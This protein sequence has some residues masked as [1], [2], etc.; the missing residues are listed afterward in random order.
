MSHYIYMRA[1][2]QFILSFII[3]IYIAQYFFPGI[4]VLGTIVNEINVWS[5]ILIYVSG[6]YA[7]LMIFLASLRSFIEKRTKSLRTED[8]VITMVTFI[9]AAFIYLYFGAVS[10]QQTLINNLQSYVWNA[11]WGVSCFFMLLYAYRRFRFM[12]AWQWG[13]AI[14]GLLWLLANSPIFPAIFPP[15]MPANDWIN[16]V[17]VAAGSRA[18]IAVVGVSAIIIALRAFMGRERVIVGGGK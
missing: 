2:P 3:G 6:I 18:S 13:L 12:T 11:T 10:P 15:I 1:L 9:I 5:T 17:F 4:P 7:S 8:D 16:R 14:G